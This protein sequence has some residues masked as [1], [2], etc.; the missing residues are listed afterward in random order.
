MKREFIISCLTSLLLCGFVATFSTPD[1]EESI[2]IPYSVAVSESSDVHLGGPR[3]TGTYSHFGVPLY[4]A[5]QG[6]GNRLPYQ[7]SWAQSPE[8]PLRFLLDI[9]QYQLTRIFLASLVLLLSALRV[10]RSWNPRSYASTQFLFTLS[11][12]A[13]AG[14]YLRQNEWSDTF[15]QTAGILAVTFLLLHRRNFVVDGSRE[16]SLLT[17]PSDFLILFGGLTLIVTGHPGVWPVAAFVIVPQV[18]TSL[19]VSHPF[20]QRFLRTVQ[21]HRSR[22]AVAIGPGLLLVAI[23]AWDLAAESSQLPG[24]SVGRLQFAQGLFADQALRGFTR[25]VLPDFVERTVSVIIAMFVLPLFRVA[26]QVFPE[27]DF[28]LRLSGAFPRGEFAGTLVVLAIMRFGRGSASGP[29][30]RSLRRVLLIM[31]PVVF[32]LAL[33]SA[34]DWFP[35]V[36]TPSGSWMTFPILLGLNSFATFVVLGQ[37]TKNQYFVRLLG[38]ANTFL[39][40]IWVLMQFSILSIH[41]SLNLKIPD[42][43]GKVEM[44]PQDAQN[45]RAIFSDGGRLAFLHS[46]EYEPRLANTE[47]I[48]VLKREKAVL[49]PAEVKIRN[50]S[51]LSTH[52]FSNG[53]IPVL[54]IEKSDLLKLDDLASFLQI[55]QVMI[56]LNDPLVSAIPSFLESLNQVQ[57]RQDS[58]QNVKFV[59]LDFVLWT[60][61]SFTSL[62]LSDQSNLGPSRC[63]VLERDCAVIQYSVASPPTRVPNLE[64]CQDPCLWNYRLEGGA[65]EQ[66]LVLPVT[67]DQALVVRNPSDMR[68]ETMNVG[69]F[70]GVGKVG[71]SQNGVFEITVRPDVRMYARILSSYVHLGTVIVLV[72]I[73][74]QRHKSEMCMRRQPKSHTNSSIAGNRRLGINQRLSHIDGGA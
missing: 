33:A 34:N 37:A 10:L 49:A 48:K 2:K 4:D 26:F 27:F 73:A 23:V 60:R 56:E 30:E 29:P 63:P 43:Y 44:T 1:I 41:P 46:K 50:V 7:S 61:T 68:L 72:L 65:K 69:G 35:A 6:T 12:L 20:R 32:T 11:L 59:A 55:S 18:L 57:G 15:M 8:W 14:L 13:P 52:N 16:S 42:R 31:Q 67:F 64:L 22:L 5:L 21:Q 28:T 9:Q 74:I 25:G 58:L 45:L 62:L 53:L 40:A 70:L 19:S 3:S 38:Y 51:H 36:I 39:I 54:S 66:T 47:V 24:W 17:S 71:D